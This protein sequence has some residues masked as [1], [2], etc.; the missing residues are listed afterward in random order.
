[1]CILCVLGTVLATCY[2]YRTWALFDRTRTVDYARSTCCVHDDEDGVGKHGDAPAQ[3]SAS[4]HNEMF[5]TAA[6]TLEADRK[7]MDRRLQKNNGCLAPVTFRRGPLLFA[8]D[9]LAENAMRM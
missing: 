7:T 4:T 2:F 8:E 5:P 1:M 3:F 9:V 6:G